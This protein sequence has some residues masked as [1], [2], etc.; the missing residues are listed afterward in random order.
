MAYETKPPRQAS[1]STVVTEGF[2]EGSEVFLVTPT[3]PPTSALMPSPRLDPQGS[4]S[5]EG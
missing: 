2:S 3:H 4:G 5:A 1:S